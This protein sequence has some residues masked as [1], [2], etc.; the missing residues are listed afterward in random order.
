MYIPDIMVT[1]VEPMLLEAEDPRTAQI[2]KIRDKSSRPLGLC[3][4]TRRA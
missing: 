3:I 2:Q 1:D 4:S